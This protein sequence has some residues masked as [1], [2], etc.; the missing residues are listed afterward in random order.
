M[1]RSI[2]LLS[3]LLL[4]TAATMPGVASAV[5][6]PHAVGMGS[7]SLWSPPQPAAPP[8]DE[9]RVERARHGSSEVYILYRGDR[10]IGYQ[11]LQADPLLPGVDPGRVLRPAVGD[12]DVIDP[13]DRLQPVDLGGILTNAPRLRDPG[14]PEW[15]GLQRDRK[16]ARGRDVPTGGH[17]PQTPLNPAPEPGTVMLLATG[18]GTVGALGAARRRWGGA[19]PQ[20]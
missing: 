20:D 15:M 4:L 19:V 3:A 1:R 13:V 17:Q 6:D 11:T 7:S 16:P 2:Q 14:Y 8:A 18:L 5:V 9:I 10:V 12:N